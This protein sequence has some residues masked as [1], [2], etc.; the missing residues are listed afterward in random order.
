M[1]L[2]SK[3]LSAIVV[4]MLLISCGEQIDAG[5]SKEGGSH[6]GS[7]LFQRDGL[8]VMV[9]SSRSFLD[10]VVVDG[11][12]F[13]EER[14]EIPAGRVVLSSTTQLHYFML[15]DQLPVVVG[16]PWLDLVKD[17]EVLRSVDSG[18]MV[19]VTKGAELDLEKIIACRPDV[20]LYDPRDASIVP[21]LRSMGISCL[22]FY[23]YLETDPLKR[24]EWI[25]VT[26]ALAGD[27]QASEVALMRVQDEYDRTRDE[28]PNLDGHSKKVLFGSFFQGKWSVAG[29]ESLLA[30]IIR[31]SGGEY[32]LNDG[33]VGSTEIDLEEFLVLIESIDVLGIV[34]HGHL[35][36]SGLISL[37]D[38]LEGIGL[39]SKELVL[40]NTAESDYFGKGVVEPHIMLMELKLLLRGKGNGN[41]IYFNIIP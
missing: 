33:E 4:F 30:E 22:P 1:L 14:I 7:L 24:L 41:G 36:R 37:D 12:K 9:D 34:N 27:R 19:N 28:F 8:I 25:Q 3:S 18:E 39:D 20:F 13:V 31:D 2:S 40:C 32:A 10:C 23:E 29:G 16:C 26:G 15:I 17:D 38:R 21:R 6:S 35:S 5:R 11:L